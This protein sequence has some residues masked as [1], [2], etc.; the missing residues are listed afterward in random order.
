MGAEESVAVSR[1]PSACLPLNGIKRS[2]ER[3]VT[4]WFYLERQHNQQMVRLEGIVVR[5]KGNSGELHI[6]RKEPLNIESF[7]NLLELSINQFRQK[8]APRICS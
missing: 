8:M 7:L 6:L 1:I 4:T 2:E 5:L 3:G